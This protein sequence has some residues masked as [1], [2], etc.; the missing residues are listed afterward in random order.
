MTAEP[1]RKSLAV[2]FKA[3]GP[4]GSFVAIFS[5][6]D[7]ID[8]YGDVARPGAI[9]DGKEVLIGAYGHD[10]HTLPV[11][12]GAIRN[13]GNLTYVDGQFNLAMALG[14]ET[15][16]AVKN[17]GDLL[18][19]SYIFVPTQYSYGEFNGVQVRFL[20]AIDVW[21]VDPV[22]KGAGQI[23][24][25]VAVKSGQ[26]IG[27]SIGAAQ[28]AVADAVARVRSLAELRAQDGRTIGAKSA[29]AIDGLRAALR[30]ALAGL[31]GI[32][33]PAKA[34]GDNTMQREAMRFEALR[35]NRLAAMVEE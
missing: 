20:E 23:T 6:Y 18:E 3:D 33:V 35:F 11:G 16:E 7:T 8:S 5:S 25:T 24:G 13:E 26:T 21:S 10:M 31:D 28:A 17:A 22:L 30:D 14:R 27:D 29:E 1:E 4:E 34:T 32:A 15:Y 9:P 2:E 19:W 12:R